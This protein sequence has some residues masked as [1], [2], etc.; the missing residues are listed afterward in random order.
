MIA[1]NRCLIRNA[2]QQMRWT[3]IL[4]LKNYFIDKKRFS[5]LN[6]GASVD[7]VFQRQFALLKQYD[8]ITED[9]RKIQLTSKGAFYSDELVH[10]FY[11]PQHQS[12]PPEDFN[13]GILNPYSL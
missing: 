13:P 1:A 8:L 3:I 11:E 2:D 6:G 7:D 5:E 9:E 10:L 12:F 4:P